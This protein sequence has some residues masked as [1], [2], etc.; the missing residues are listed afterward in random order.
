MLLT[1]EI[2]RLNKLLLKKN[3]PLKNNQILQ[4][5]LRKLEEQVLQERNHFNNTIGKL[6]QEKKQMKQQV[7]LRISQ[8][9]MEN[10]NKRKI[11]IADRES[12]E[13]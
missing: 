9:L 13:I 8:L 1:N 12:K 10:I 7:N 3:K 4:S 6:K 2:R 11:L 5:T